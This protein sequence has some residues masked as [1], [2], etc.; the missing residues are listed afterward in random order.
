MSQIWLELDQL[1]KRVFIKNLYDKTH[2]HILIHNPSVL[3]PLFKALSVLRTIYLLCNEIVLTG[4]KGGQENETE[5]RV[6][7]KTEKLNPAP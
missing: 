3:F 1:L 2:Y 7:E 6:I 4:K 5:F